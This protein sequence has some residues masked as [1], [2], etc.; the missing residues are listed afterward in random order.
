MSKDEENGMDKNLLNIEHPE[1]HCSGN[2]E[3][4]IPENSRSKIQEI[5]KNPKERLYLGR[6]YLSS[7][8]DNTR[9]FDE[10]LKFSGATLVKMSERKLRSHINWQNSGVVF[11]FKSN[12]YKMLN[13]VEA[14]TKGKLPSN[15]LDIFK[16]ALY[17]LIDR[18]VYSLKCPIY[19]QSI[20]LLFNN[21]PLLY[22]LPITFAGEKTIA[23]GGEVNNVHWFAP[24]DALEREAICSP[25]PFYRVLCRFRI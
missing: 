25:S 15:A 17:T 13:R 21:K 8:Y 1:V 23:Y 4:I 2:V 9:P 10:I 16:Y 24:L 5:Q 14:Y 11:T 18:L 6:A 20:T 22:E 12:S 19:V 3:V 7:I